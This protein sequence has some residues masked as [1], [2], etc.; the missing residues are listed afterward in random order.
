MLKFFSL[1]SA[2]WH[3]FP[4]KWAVAANC[5]KN[6]QGSLINFAELRLGL[7]RAEFL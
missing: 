1:F 4:W 6:N 2:S 7:A 5:S 3:L